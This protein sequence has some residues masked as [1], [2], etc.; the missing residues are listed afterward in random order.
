M[1]PPEKQ[2]IE[3]RKADETPK[4]A[5]FTTKHGSQG[6]TNPVF[7]SYTQRNPDLQADYQKNWAGKGVS[8]TEYGAMHYAKYGKSEG[9]SL[10][11]PR[12][13]EPASIE[14]PSSGPSAPAPAPAPAPTVS[15]PTPSVELSTFDPTPVGIENVEPLLSEVVIEGPQSEVVQNRVASMLDTN[16]P[17]FQQAA[18][19]AMRRLAA[20]GIT[21]SSMAQE[22]VMN[23]VMNVVIP[24]A[25]MDAQVFNQQR[26]ANQ[27]FSNQFRQQQNEAFYQQMSQRLDGAIKETLAH[28]AGGYRLD[29]ARMNDLTRRYVADLQA[30]AGLEIAGM[31]HALG[32]EGLRVQ[33]AGDLVSIIGNP[34]ASQYY[35]DLLSGNATS[36]V[37][38]AATWGEAYQNPN[39]PS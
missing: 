7:A 24:I 15:A 12:R 13:E 35:Y 34:Q 39:L 36:P 18:G 23:A 27:G 28:I 2:F 4:E 37:N 1:P 5:E 6:V 22:E 26:L 14:R 20:R 11:A 38:F 16:S 10:E 25:Q 9:R 21:N 3:R 32:M 19:Q 17:L 31:E 29:E 33:S 8:P 30:S